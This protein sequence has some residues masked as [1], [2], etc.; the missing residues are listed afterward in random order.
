MQFLNQQL[1][2]I[3]GSSACFMQKPLTL[4]L[5]DAWIL[6]THHSN[7]QVDALIAGVPVITTCIARQIG[8]LQDIEKPIYDRS[9]LKN[10]AYKQW[11]LQEIEKGQAWNELQSLKISH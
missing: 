5:N 2:K 6:I 10:L 8:K 11:N 9:W 4:L 3:S 1:L 7:A